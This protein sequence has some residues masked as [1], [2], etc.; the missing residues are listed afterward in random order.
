MDLFDIKIGKTAIAAMSS[1]ALAHIGDAVYELLVRT[2]LAEAG[3]STAARIH[4]ESVKMVAAPA[5]ARA[6]EK[7]LSALT[8]E[9]AAV[10]RRGRNVK[11]NSVP[12]AATPGEYHEATALEALFGYLYLNGNRER[13]SEL[14][15]MMMEGGHAS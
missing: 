4:R 5:Q 2:H 7:I 8:D 15:E 13:I 1:L 9:E 14:F 10:F 11:V 3:N 12:H 6:A